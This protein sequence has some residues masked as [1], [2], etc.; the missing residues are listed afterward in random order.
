[1]CVIIP[2]D[3][4]YSQHFTNE[5]NKIRNINMGIYTS[6]CW[7]SILK[8]KEGKNTIYIDRY[9]TNHGYFQDLITKFLE[10][11]CFS[12]ADISICRVIHMQTSDVFLWHRLGPASIF[13]TAL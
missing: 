4:C 1:M 5:G 13:R 7:D 6:Q 12:V 11:T 2:S 9:D 10:V 8:S 3:I